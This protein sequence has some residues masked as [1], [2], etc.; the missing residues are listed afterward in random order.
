MPTAAARGADGGRIIVRGSASAIQ[1]ASSVGAGAGLGAGGSGGGT[2]RTPGRVTTL[3]SREGWSQDSTAP[4]GSAGGGSGA[5]AGTTGGAMA[6]AGGTASRRGG[7]I[8]GVFRSDT[9]SE[10]L[11][12][13]GVACRPSARKGS[14]SAAVLGPASGAA[15]GEPA[16]GSVPLPPR[17]NSASSELLA[18]GAC[19]GRS[20]M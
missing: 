2:R 7:A 20:G 19:S 16:K 8:H 1:P 13:T 6:G 17:L 11:G 15:S 9:W 12:A 10:A 14:A 3:V 4:G 18:E 5:G